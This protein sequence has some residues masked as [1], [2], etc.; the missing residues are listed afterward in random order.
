MSDGEWCEAA[1]YIVRCRT[2]SSTMYSKFAW[3]WMKS[4]SRIIANQ[5]T[6][7]WKDFQWL[8]C[9]VTTNWRRYSKNCNKIG[10]LLANGP[11]TTTNGK[12]DNAGARSTFLPKLYYA[13][14]DLIDLNKGVIGIKL[15]TI[16][17]K[18]AFRVLQ[19][20]TSFR[21]NKG[22]KG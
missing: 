13:T 19:N 16:Y 14:C 17:N 3:N 2:S 5:T 7:I 9:V 10:N 12:T 20:S 1:I 18:A 11:E 6:I 22:T 4:S 21:L 8:L 15:S